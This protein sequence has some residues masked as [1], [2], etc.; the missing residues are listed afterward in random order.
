[1][2]ERRNRC[3]TESG[4]VECRPCDVRQTLACGICS[5]ASGGLRLRGLPEL[6]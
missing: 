5:S 1:M 3:V 6:L 4:F 2:C